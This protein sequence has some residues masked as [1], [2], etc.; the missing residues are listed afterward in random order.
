MCEDPQKTHTH[1]NRILQNGHDIVVSIF[2]MDTIYIFIYFHLPSD[3]VN[4][5]L[6]MFLEFTPSR[7]SL[8]SLS[9]CLMGLSHVAPMNQTANTNH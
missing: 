4:E 1:K 6:T 8:L 7:S 5:T 9:L 3:I 2:L